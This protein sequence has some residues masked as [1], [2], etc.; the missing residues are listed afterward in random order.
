M[1]LTLF[2]LTRKMLFEKM[3]LSRWVVNPHVGLACG[4]IAFM[5][6]MRRAVK[7]IE[8]QVTPDN[9]KDAYISSVFVVVGTTTMSTVVGSLV[10]VPV[11]ATSLYGAVTARKWLGMKALDYNGSIIGKK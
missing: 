2:F 4:A 9:T 3:L 8:K 11:I 5:L 7:H 1:K 6:S 10:P